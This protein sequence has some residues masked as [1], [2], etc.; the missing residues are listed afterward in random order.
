M[1]RCF[2]LNWREETLKVKD[3]IILEVKFKVYEAK[4]EILRAKC[5]SS[6]AR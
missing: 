6:V 2:N 5:M 1:R 3:D 4:H